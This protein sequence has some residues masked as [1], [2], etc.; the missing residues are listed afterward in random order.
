MPTKKENLTRSKQTG[1]TGGPNPEQSAKGSK[2]NPSARNGS[3]PEAGR[4]LGG[5]PDSGTTTPIG[6]QGGRDR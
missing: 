5:G 1:Q 3:A 2:A 4:K 6:S